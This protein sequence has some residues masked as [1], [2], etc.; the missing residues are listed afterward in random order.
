MTRGEIY[1]IF[2]QKLLLESSKD[3]V[4]LFF[5]LLRGLCLSSFES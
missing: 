3:S 4:L 1:F 2:I 5:D